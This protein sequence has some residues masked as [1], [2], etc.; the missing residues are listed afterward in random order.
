MSGWINRR[1]FGNTLSTAEDIPCQKYERMTEFCELDTNR[2][3]VQP[4]SRY[5]LEEVR[6]IIEPIRLSGIPT[7]IRNG[8]L[9]K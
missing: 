9:Q 2:E 6:E 8:H 1:L 7:Q 4:T 3:E 5:N